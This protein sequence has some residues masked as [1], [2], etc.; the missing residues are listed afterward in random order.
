[1]KKAIKTLVALVL[2]LVLAASL[3]A[4]AWADG[5]ENGNGNGGSTPNYKATVTVNGL[6]NDETVNAYKLIS[7]DADYNNLVIADGY[8]TYLK[9]KSGKINATD[10]ELAE[11]IVGEG[12]SITTA[13]M[14]EG[15]LASENNSLPA[16]KTYP[17]DANGTATLNNLDPGYYLLTV[18]TT[19]QIS[20]LYRP[21]SAYIYPQ[22]DK[23]YIEVG[24]EHASPQTSA[25][26]TAK[27]V[28]GPTID[29]KVKTVTSNAWYDTATA[30]VGDTAEFYVKIEIPRYPAGSKISMEL[31]DT[32]E[33]MTYNSTEGAKLYSN[34]NNDGTFSDKDVINAAGAL[35]VD[36]T[37]NRPIFTLGYDAIMGTDQNAKTV[38]LVYKAT[39]AQ[40][41]AAGG[42]AKNSAK[43]TY[44]N[45]GTPAMTRTTDPSSV[46]VYNYAFKLEKKD[47]TGWSKLSGAE[48]TIC[49]DEACTNAISFDKTGTDGVYEKN[50]TGTVT[51]IPADFTV[52]GL[53]PGKYYVKEMTTP[54]GYFAPAGNFT[55]T[56]T[57]AMDAATFKHN[58]ELDG[59]NSSFTANETDKDGALIVNKVVDNINKNTYSV[60]LKNSVIPTLPSTGGAGTAVFTVAGVAVMVLAAVLFLRRKKEE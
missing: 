53:A 45:I 13:E 40:G 29:K 21:M 44:A 9:N 27:S 35:T 18:T 47:N 57:A 32:M 16:A 52:K 2:A 43:L 60:Q 4:A 56:L 58:G 1:M 50:T 24:D 31:T 19:P 8:R 15:Y 6:E 10:R 17:A 23:L 14:L 55:L 46:T 59:G 49:T 11:W 34:I 28:N 36:T 54:K 7:F 48:F 42:S 22:G 51:K 25:T 39:V 26:L 5:G 33:N 3:S 37:A 38:Y 41:A 30:G 20:K 12:I